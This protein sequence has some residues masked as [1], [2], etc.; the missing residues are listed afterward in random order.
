MRKTQTHFQTPFGNFDLQRFPKCGDKNLRAWNSADSFLLDALY[1]SERELGKLWIVNDAFGA[2]SVALNAS[3]IHH[4]SDSFLSHL[5]CQNNYH[6]NELSLDRMTYVESTQALSGDC[7]D[8]LVMKIPKSLSLLEDQLQRLAPMITSS[9][10]VIAASMSKHMHRSTIDLFEKNLGPTHTSLAKKKARLL[11]C[12][13]DETRTENVGLTW[14]KSV[15]SFEGGPLL[16][17]H[18]NVFSREKFDIGSRYLIERLEVGEGRERV[19]DL[20]CGNGVLGIYYGMKNPEASLFFVDESYMALQSARDGAEENRIKNARFFK[21]DALDTSQGDH[22]SFFNAEES[23]DVVLCNPPFHNQF[24]I[25]VQTAHKMF[26]HAHRVLREGGVLWV[27]GNSHL[28]YHIQMK[29][30]FSKVVHVKSAKDKH[31]KNKKFV[32]FKATK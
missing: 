12:D 18:A 25:G 22:R 23:V 4:Y 32:V 5:S 13:I 21:A 6:D 3:M 28:A 19:I 20:G 15:P 29:K 10:K 11:F 2:L 31:S 14:P 30:L 27:I 26:D 7:I 16:V 1:E 8:T 17:N 9:T 24:E